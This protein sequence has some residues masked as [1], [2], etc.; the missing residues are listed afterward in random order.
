MEKRLEKIIPWQQYHLCLDV[1]VRKSNSAC[2]HAKEVADTIVVILIFIRVATE[3]PDPFYL[4][5]VTEKEEKNLTWR[6]PNPNSS[7]YTG[8]LIRHGFL[9]PLASASCQRRGRKGDQW[10]WRQGLW[11]WLRPWGLDAISSWCICSSF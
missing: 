5:A 8:K 7:R 4:F 9:L 3:K 10:W 2:H 11:Q 6:N 1:V